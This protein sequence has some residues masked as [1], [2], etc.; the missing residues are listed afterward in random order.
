MNLA[1]A[2]DGAD[3][4]IERAVM[5]NAA[6]IVEQARREFGWTLWKTSDDVRGILDLV[7][8]VPRPGQTMREAVR[9]TVAYLEIDR[10]GGLILN[11]HG[12][13]LGTV[14]QV[15]GV[16][17]LPERRVKSEPVLLV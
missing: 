1:V 2:P 3:Q 15:P 10:L 14:V 16:V 11:G 4:T 17:G 9:A 8:V 12:F 13:D 7:P 6:D 5:R